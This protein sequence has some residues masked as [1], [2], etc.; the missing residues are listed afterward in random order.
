MVDFLKTT[1]FRLVRRL[2][3]GQGSVVFYVL[4]YAENDLPDIEADL[5]AEIQVQIGVLPAFGVA[6][7]ILREGAGLIL[8]DADPI[9]ILRIDCWSPELVAL[10]DT[11]V[12]RLERSGAQFLF[13][14]TEKLADGCS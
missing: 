13:L 4:I 5:R 3:T 8:D 7:T 2:A 6:S 11:H 1:A 14:A 12:I 9:R 10:L